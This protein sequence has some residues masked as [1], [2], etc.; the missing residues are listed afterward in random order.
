LIGRLRTPATSVS[1][2]G[3]NPTPAPKRGIDISKARLEGSSITRSR[4]SRAY[5]PAELT[6]EEI[7]LSVSQA[8]A[9]NRK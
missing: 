3:N 6:P 4:V 7:I 1:A 9:C 5:F 2:Y 8:R